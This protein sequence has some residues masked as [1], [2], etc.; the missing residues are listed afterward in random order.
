MNFNSRD[1]EI[2]L[3]RTSELRRYMKAVLPSL[4]VEYFHTASTIN[5]YG[6]CSGTSIAGSEFTP[7]HSPEKKYVSVHID[8]CTI[9]CDNFKSSPY[10]VIFTQSVLL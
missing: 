4:P 6:S 3:V 7:L 9:A 2:F 10:N 1:N 5:T 8:Y